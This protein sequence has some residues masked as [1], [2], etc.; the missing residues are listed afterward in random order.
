MTPSLNFQFVQFVQFISAGYQGL[1]L[2]LMLEEHLKLSHISIED[3]EYALLFPKTSRLLCALVPLITTTSKFRQS[4]IKTGL[5]DYDSWNKDL[6]DRL[7]FLYRQWDKNKLCHKPEL[8]V[9]R[10]GVDTSLFKVFGQRRSVNDQR[11]MHEWS[12][13]QRCHALLAMCCWTLVGSF[14]ILCY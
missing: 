4:L 12:I 8:F 5:C 3:L 1:G 2:D 9:K 10:Y 14:N 7:E 11:Q 13:F 6:S